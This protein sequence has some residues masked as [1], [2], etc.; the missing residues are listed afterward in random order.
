[1]EVQIPHVKEQFWGRKG[2]GRGQD[3]HVHQSIYLKQNKSTFVQLP[4]VLW[5][6]GSRKGILPGVSRKLYIPARKVIELW[7]ETRV[8]IL[9][10]T[11]TTAFLMWQLIVTSRLGRT[12]YQLLL[13]KISW[14]DRNAK[15][16][17]KFLVVWWI[18]TASWYQPNEFISWKN[19][20]AR[21]WHGYPS[22]ARCK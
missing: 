17:Y 3:R 22:A 12:E 14:W 18:L 16:R 5:R 15:I 11:P 7:I 10:A 20:V 9:W 1:M 4:S 21:Y 2:A 13:M 6:L 19:W 8:V